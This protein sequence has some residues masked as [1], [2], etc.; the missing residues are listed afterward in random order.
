MTK[1]KNI[2][3]SP[4]RYPGG[5]TNLAPFIKAVLDENNL[6]GIDY[7]E[8][9]A[10]GAGVALSLLLENYVSTITI[11]DIDRSVY[12]F[13]HSVVNA[14][15]A[16][17]RLIHKTPITLS[18]RQKALEIQKQNAKVDLLTLGFST[19]FLN[20]TNISGILTAGVIGGEAQNGKYK[21]NERFNKPELI[22]KIEHIGRFKDK[23]RVTRKDTLRLLEKNP[24]G[25]FFYIDPPYIQK[26]KKLYTNFYQKQDHQNL[27]STIYKKLSQ[28]NYW[29]VSYDDT[30]FIRETFKKCSKRL[31]W[32]ISYG[33]SNR[34]IAKE[35]IFADNKLKINKSRKWL[36][37]YA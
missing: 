15:D 12:G 9:Y 13:W 30:E 3:Y 16:L 2:F 34:K 6:A 14:N 22:R 5:K 11:N 4:L 21:I 33:T 37:D 29:V 25:K 24:S 32:Q 7:V 23:I 35:I 28:K 8:P 10:G 36:P 31:S 18:Q 26:G 19:F 20:R 17:C 1:T 27:V